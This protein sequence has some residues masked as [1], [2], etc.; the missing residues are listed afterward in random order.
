MSIFFFFRKTNRL[1]ESKNIF[2]SIVNNI[3]FRR[4]SI[5]LFMNKT[6]LLADKLE[7]RETN[8]KNYFP[9]FSGKLS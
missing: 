2:E 5:I 1:E 4:V 9:N 8:I 6:D 7:R 3:I